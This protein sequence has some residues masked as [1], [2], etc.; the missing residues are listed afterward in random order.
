MKLNATSSARR[1]SGESGASLKEMIMKA[2]GNELKVG[3]DNSGQERTLSRKSQLLVIAA[4]IVLGA[5][6]VGSAIW[7]SPDLSPQAASQ[8]EGDTPAPTALEFEYFPAQY[9]NQG[10]EIEEH[11]QAF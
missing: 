11:I 10:K 7:T 1:R 5:L 6:L 9:V 4:V 2:V 3:G 8:A